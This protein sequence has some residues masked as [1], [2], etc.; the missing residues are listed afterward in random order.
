[1]AE[2]RNRVVS[3]IVRFVLCV[4]LLGAAGAIYGMLYRTRPQPARSDVANQARRVL[5]ME[6]HAV[7]V[8]RQWDGFGT[9]RAMDSADVPARVTATVISIPPTVQDGAAVEA[10]DLLVQLDESDFARE[11]ELSTQRMADVSA[12]LERLDIEVKSWETRTK[13]A[14][15]RVRLAQAEYDRVVD[16]RKKQAARPSFVGTSNSM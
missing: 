6:A 7:D 3:W 9:A 4:M 15:D 14:A 2:R 1:M 13:L 12:Q 11:V 8:R 16:A 5:V 10:G